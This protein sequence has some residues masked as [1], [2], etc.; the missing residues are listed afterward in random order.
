MCVFLKFLFDFASFVVFVAFAYL[1]YFFLS[2]QR[3]THEV[4]FLL[5][6]GCNSIAHSYRRLYFVYSHRDKV[7]AVTTH[8][9]ELQFFF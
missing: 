5:T 9:A 2:S 3:E 7:K 6:A 4:L 1:N 8:L